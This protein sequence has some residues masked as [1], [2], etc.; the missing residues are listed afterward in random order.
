MM[1]KKVLMVVLLAAALG[2]TGLQQA[3]A[4]DNRN[5]REHQRYSHRLDDA[6]N[7]RL[8]KFRTDTSDLQKQIVMKRAEESALIRSETPNIEAVKKA[9]GEL[10]DLKQTMLE[11]AK[12]AG[13]FTLKRPGIIHGKFVERKEKLDKFLADSKDIRKQMSINRAEKKALMNSRT[14]DPQA[15]AKVA[16]KLFDLRRMLHDKAAA[17]GLPRHFDRVD[18]ERGFH[19]RH[20]LDGGNFGIKG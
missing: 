4:N 3:S 9:A 7:A 13:L 11:K 16:G 8:E 18:R 14:P 19:N 17:A 20:F 5:P 15:V 12:A 1:K 10:F 2:I 6:T